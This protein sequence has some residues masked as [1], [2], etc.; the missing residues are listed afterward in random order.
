M[1]KRRLLQSAGLVLII[2]V[3]GLVAGFVGQQNAL[4]NLSFKN[5][6]AHQAAQAMKNDEFFS[7]YKENTLIIRGKVSSATKQGAG[8]KV[9]LETSSTYQLFCDLSNDSSNFKV[10]D[11]IVI[12][13]IGGSAVR[14][15]SAVLMPDCVSP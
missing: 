9:G 1:T 6:S 12:E 10:G 3:V 7:D 11:N 14:Q 8:T 2:I 15:S 13:A 5:V 4:K